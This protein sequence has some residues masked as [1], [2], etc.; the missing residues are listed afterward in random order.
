MPDLIRHPECLGEL[1]SGFRRNDEQKQKGN[2]PQG[3]SNIAL[4]WIMHFGV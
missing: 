1:D 4:I 3:D 2:L